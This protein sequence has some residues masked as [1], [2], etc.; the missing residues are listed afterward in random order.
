MN[1]ENSEDTI[2]SIATHVS[3]HIP[4]A[5]SKIFINAEVMQDSELIYYSYINNSNVLIESHDMVARFNISRRFEMQFVINFGDL[6]QKLQNEIFLETNN[7]WSVITMI[8]E[9]NGRFHVHYEYVDLMIGSS[10]ARREIFK[11]KYLKEY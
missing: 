10:L 11:D 8:I 3:E 4:E 9:S 1:H 2:Q 6:L 5:W 7:K